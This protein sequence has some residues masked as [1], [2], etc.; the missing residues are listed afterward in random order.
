MRARQRDG[1]QDVCF[2]LLLVVLEPDD[3]S[4]EISILSG[5]V[6][7]L[8]AHFSKSTFSD[9]AVAKYSCFYP[10]NNPFSITSCKGMYFLLLYHQITRRRSQFHVFNKT[11]NKSRMSV[12]SRHVWVLRN[13]L[14]ICLRSP[15]VQVD[16]C[17]AGIEVQVRSQ[18]VVTV[19]KSTMD[20][21]QEG[22]GTVQA[23]APS[24]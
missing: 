20:H 19:R 17:W 24:M 15:R 1:T 4:F 7:T 22:K 23:R 21:R 11:E 10:R 3:C 8:L 12:T 16:I 14:T 6:A 2:L 9:A 18:Y 5:A 13:Q